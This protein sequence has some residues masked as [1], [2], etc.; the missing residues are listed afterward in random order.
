MPENFKV[1]GFAGPDWFKQHLE[2]YLKTDGKH[3]HLVDF[4]AVGGPDNVPCLILDTVGR[5]SGDEKMLP[6]I[7]GTDGKNFVIVASKGGA[8]EHPAWFLNLQA[9]PEVKFQ[10]VDKKYRGRARIAAGTERKS[11]YE[12]MTKIFPAYAQYQAKT[13]REIPVVILEPESEIDRL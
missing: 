3:G 7:Y 11:L 1:T 9:H 13:D 10:V 4:T 8:P 2:D 12:M 5:K 6:L